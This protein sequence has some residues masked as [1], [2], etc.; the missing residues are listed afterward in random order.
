MPGTNWG[1]LCT[2]T[3]CTFPTAVGATGRRH[4]QV[5]E[6]VPSGAPMAESPVQHV[7]GRGEEDKEGGGIRD[8]DLPGL[9]Q[10]S[11]WPD[12]TEQASLP[13]APGTNLPKGGEGTPTTGGVHKPV[14]Q[15]GDVESNP[16]P[17]GGPAGHPT[18]RTFLLSQQMADMFSVEVEKQAEAGPSGSRRTRLS[19]IQRVTCELGGGL[20]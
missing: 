5:L 8:P 10:C 16:G 20:F 1:R 12:G 2:A 6:G 18:L 19:L 4:E 17:G 13:T 11:P 15:C 9:A 3:Q 7:R 14:L